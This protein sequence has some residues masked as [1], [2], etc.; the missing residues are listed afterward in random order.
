MTATYEQIITEANRRA[1]ERGWGGPPV[2]H[3]IIEVTREGWKPADPVLLLAREFLARAY[4]N[5]G[6]LFIAYAETVRKGFYDKGPVIEAIIDA[7]NA[8]RTL[9]VDIKI[10]RE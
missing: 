3:Y 9:V 2:E 4:E 8:G 6:G 1:T 5:R 10:G 7:Y